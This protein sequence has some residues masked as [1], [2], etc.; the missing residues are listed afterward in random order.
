MQQNNISIQDACTILE[1]P[2]SVWTLHQRMDFKQAVECLESF[3]IVVKTQRKLLAK[4]YHPDK[5]NG[6]DSKMKEINNIVDLLMKVKLQ[7][8]K[9]MV[10]RFNMSSSSTTT[11]TTSSTYY[12]RW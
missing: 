12:S 8:P 9:P 6:D 3:K 11:N 10:I 4:R 7:P 5:A 2:L 1:L